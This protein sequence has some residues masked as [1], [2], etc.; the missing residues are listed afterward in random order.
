MPPG[1]QNGSVGFADLPPLIGDVPGR[2]QVPPD[3][4]RTPWAW[5]GAFSMLVQ[6]NRDFVDLGVS[7]VRDDLDC[8]AFIQGFSDV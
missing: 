1:Q 3:T 8:L 4:M 2:D 6:Q 7:V 5:P